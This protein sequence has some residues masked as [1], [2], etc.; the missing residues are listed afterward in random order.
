[1][2]LTEQQLRF[3]ETF[4]FLKF[5][6]LLQPEIAAITEAFEEVWTESSTTHD[7]QSRTMIVPF[8]DRHETLCGLLDDPNVVGIASSILGD[9]FN[10]ITSDGNFFVG[11]TLWH[12]DKD[13]SDGHT[14]IKFALYLDPVGPD[15][16]CLRVIPGSHRYG[17]E[18]AEAVHR[19]VPVVAESRPEEVWGVGGSEVPAFPLVSE[20]G[21]VV[22]FD[23]GTKHSAWGGGDRRR[24]FTINCEERRPAAELPKIREEVTRTKDQ[25]GMAH[26]YGETMLET[27]DTDR[28][29]HLE[30]RLEAERTG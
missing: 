22:V 2:R 14:A 25:Y 4:G 9:D 16:G 12:S 1:M 27:A 10:Y 18:F 8:I 26:V 11:G 17:D 13:A 6:G 28:M 5:T 15:S 29:V 21:D 20:P 23:H 24:M 30:Q 7:H 3:F 19:A